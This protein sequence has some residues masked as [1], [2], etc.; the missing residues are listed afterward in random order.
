M[1]TTAA[2]KPG[3]SRRAFGWIAAIV[4]ILALALTGAWYYAANRL[5]ASVRA[6]I[7]AAAGGGTAIGCDNREVFG[8]PFRIGLRC[9]ATGMEVPAKGIRASAGALRTAAQLYQPTRVV[10]EL[11]GPLLLDLPTAPPLDIRWRLLDSSARFSFDGL[12]R[13]DVVVEAPDVALADPAGARSPL[14]ASN[15]LEAHARRN[16]A[17]LDVAF[18]NSGIAAA[19]P[20]YE[21]LPPFDLAADLTVAGAAGWMAGERPGNTFGEALRGR[22]GT[23]RS[24]A[25]RSSAPG[26]P[27][28]EL[29]GPF[30]VDREGRVSGRF[31]VAMSDP[32]AIADL[33]G[34][35]VPEFGGLAGTLASGI[36]MVGRQENGQTVIEIDVK[37]GKASLGFI[38]L[39]R[40]PP[41]E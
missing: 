36:G 20:G 30:A 13:L 34:R 12:Q 7:E 18:S 39:G 29:S 15:H 41:L 31:R 3:R 10:A 38:P 28:A 6:A 21:A 19:R 37:R 32:A 27:A 26:N 11:D 14:L 23:L 4:V 9:A 40:I 5:D 17:D 2:A 1:T 35:F 22:S 33:A 16:G 8:Y 24:L 25:L